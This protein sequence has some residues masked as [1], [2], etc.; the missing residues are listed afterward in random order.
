M[1]FMQNIQWFFIITN[2]NNRCKKK[3]AYDFM[4]N[5]NVN[6]WKSLQKVPA[7]TM[8]VPLIIGAIITTVTQGFF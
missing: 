1:I 5:K 2:Y 3:E 7:G 8:F 6:I 4:E